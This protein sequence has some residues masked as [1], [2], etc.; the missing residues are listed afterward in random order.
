M[1]VS[2]VRKRVQ[3]TIER[4]K[5]RAGEKRARTDAAQR[6]YPSFLSGIAVPMFRQI[7]SALKAEGYAFT[8]FTPAGGVRLM[9]DK[10]ADDL[11]ELSLDTS[12][13][14]PA[15]MGHVKRSRGRRVIES[16]R[17]IATGPIAQISE[18]Q[19]LDFLIAELE[20]FVDR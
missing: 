12:G 1:E 13:D 7:A 11:I 5:A 8:V 10:N 19:L 3:A 14:E 18:E 2:A 6:E 15:V 20:P 17:A 4:S 9:S 16:E